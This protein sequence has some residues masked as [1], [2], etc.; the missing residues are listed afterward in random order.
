MKTNNLSSG[1][2][3]ILIAILLLPVY[4]TFGEGFKYIVAPYILYLI[5][6]CNPLFLPALFIHFSPGSTIS[7]LILITIFIL[8]IINIPLFLKMK[9]G[10]ALLLAF[11]PFPILFYQ[12]LERIFILKLNFV[13]IVK[14]L[15]FYLGIFPFFYGILVF[16]KLNETIWKM[17]IGVLF[18]L[19]FLK[20]VPGVD[21]NI[22][23]YWFSFPLFFTL[24]GATLFYG[25]SFK[26]SSAIIWTSS[27]FLAITVA[28]E[29]FGLKFTLIFSGF[30]ALISL[31]LSVR[32][33]TFWLSLLTRPRTIIISVL[34]VAGI[35]AGVNKYGNVK[36]MS[37]VEQE[38]L[39]YLDWD[40][41]WMLLQYKTFDD[42]AVIWEGGWE[43]LNNKDMLWPPH[44]PPSY[45]YYNASGSK[46]KNVE[47]GI[48][49]IG[50]ELMRNYGII[51]GIIITLTYAFMLIIG[52]GKLLFVHSRYRY[53]IV[54][55]ATC[56]GAGWVGGLVG[57]H[58][59]MPTFSLILMGFCGISFAYTIYLK[60]QD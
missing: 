8:T 39:S 18:I 58:V 57:Q 50:L 25:R 48:H 5:W 24:L 27:L 32:D 45:S 11:L 2:L 29:V 19:P 7:I 23:G 36:S 13:D 21:G 16:P 53:A 51:I 15:S 46:I 9:L 43:M 41:F 30:L 52:P 55:S 33:S 4:Q 22:R 49:N 12:T 1:I 3:H 20:F 44:S 14:P 60:T 10:A 59:L 56:I 17:L 28:F 6:Q 40:D 37:K 42:R 54:F 34:L 26:F 47:F 35:I 38:S 31:T